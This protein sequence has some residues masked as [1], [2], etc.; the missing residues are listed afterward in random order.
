MLM[1]AENNRKAHYKRRIKKEISKMKKGLFLLLV[2]SSLLSKGQYKFE[3]GVVLNSKGLPE[4]D[5]I[6]SDD[7]TSFFLLRDNEDKYF[8]ERYSKTDMSLENST[9]LVNIDKRNFYKIFA[10]NGRFLLLT[11]INDKKNDLIEMQSQW[12]D[13]DGK[14]TQ[15]QKLSKVNKT[16]NNGYVTINAGSYF[17]SSLSPDKSKLLLVA[18]DQHDQLIEKFASVFSAEKLELIWSGKLAEPEPY[19]IEQSPGVPFTTA[20]DVSAS[21]G[22]II[23]NEGDVV[24]IGYK[25]IPFTRFPE[26]K[27]IYINKKGKVNQIEINPSD[28]RFINPE[29]VTEKFLLYSSIYEDQNLDFKLSGLQRKVWGDTLVVSGF[30]SEYITLDSL[31]AGIFSLIVDLKTLNKSLR[32]EY[33]PESIKKKVYNTHGAF[34][35]AHHIVPLE[36]GFYLIGEEAFFD[37]NNYIKKQKIERKS[38]PIEINSTGQQRYTDP[39]PYAS[40]ANYF[41]QEYV[42]TIVCKVQYNGEIEWVKVLPKKVKTISSGGPSFSYPMEGSYYAGVTGNEVYI[43]QYGSVDGTAINVD[44]FNIDKISVSGD[45]ESTTINMFKINSKGNVNVFNI[46]QK[47]SLQPDI[48]GSRNLKRPLFYQFGAKGVVYVNTKDQP[49]FAQIIFN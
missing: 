11:T 35:L 45:I 30:F 41:T 14:V 23:N 39:N 49:H 9:L 25:R 13:R 37:M 7:N 43:M 29:N 46:N 1:I 31:K 28:N 18:W 17:S 44:G 40:K 21:N 15:S 33:F 27:Y 3:E 24:S 10:I 34:K 8:F 4:P 48:K 38:A 22:F 20:Y 42:G 26:P 5:R 36:D 16:K 2:L 12:L 32:F 19:V 6:I 47:F